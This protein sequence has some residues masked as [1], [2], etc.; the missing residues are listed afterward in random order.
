[1]KFNGHIP[2]QEYSIQAGKIQVSFS[3]E[4]GLIFQIYLSNIDQTSHKKD[5]HY[6][7]LVKGHK[8]D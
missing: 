6:I 3:F 4:K 5:L 1:M 7:F 8:V 2:A